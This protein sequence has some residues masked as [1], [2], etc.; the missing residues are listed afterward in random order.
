M[1]GV[2][3]LFHPDA[4]L[5]WHATGK[6][7]AAPREIAAT[8]WILLPHLQFIPALGRVL[9]LLELPQGIRHLSNPGGLPA[10]LDAFLDHRMP[11]LRPR[12][13]HERMDGLARRAARVVIPQIS[14]L[15]LSRPL[16]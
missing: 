12:A 3:F 11:G 10:L 7:L 1:V 8:D 15:E 14:I 16:G 9:A 6:S 13:R 4:L 5:E 2:S